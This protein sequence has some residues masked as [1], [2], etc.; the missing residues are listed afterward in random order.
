MAGSSSLNHTRI[1]RADEFHSG[2]GM[3][4]V[5]DESVELACAGISV[6]NVRMPAV[7][8]AQWMC[9]GLRPLRIGNLL[10]C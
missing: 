7:R 5:V 9:V 8:F 1:V 2:T 4:G 6:R 3:V 10:P